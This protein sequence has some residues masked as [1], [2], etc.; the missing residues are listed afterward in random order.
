MTYF[1]EHFKLGLLFHFVSSTKLDYA[2]NRLI[3][4]ICEVLVDCGC[5]YCLTS[6]GLSCVA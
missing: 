3:Q 6:R 2:N 1:S 5:I 4:I